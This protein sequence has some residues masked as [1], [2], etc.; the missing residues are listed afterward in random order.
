VLQFARVVFSL[1]AL[2]SLAQ[3]QQAELLADILDAP[4]YGGNSSIHAYGTTGS[5]HEFAQVGGWR[6]FQV[7][8]PEHGAELWRSLGT[9]A[10]TELVV[11]IDP[12]PVGSYPGAFCAWGQ[13]LFFFASPRPGGRALYVSTGKGAVSLLDIGDGQHS[14]FFEDLIEWSGGIAFV[15]DRDGRRELWV[16]DGTQKG[17]RV[18]L[19]NEMH[20]IHPFCSLSWCSARS[21]FWFLEG[22]PSALDGRIWTF[23]PKS[24]KLALLPGAKAPLHLPYGYEKH[25]SILFSG[26]HAFWLTKQGLTQSQASL[27]VGHLVSYD[28]QAATEHVLTQAPVAPD[29]S[30]AK[31]MGRQ[32]YFFS[33]FEKE[34]ELWR[35][36][37]TKAGT[38]LVKKLGAGLTV[39]SALHGERA[40]ER[41]VSWQGK[42][43]F[44]VGRPASGNTPANH[45]M[46]WSTDGTAAGTQPMPHALPSPNS[47]ITLLSTGTEL[48]ASIHAFTPV[49]PIT[50]TPQ[51]LRWTAQG[52][53][54]IRRG[55]PGDLTVH[56]RD[57]A[58]L[59]NGD[60]L[61]DWGDYS[62]ESPQKLGSGVELCAYDP[63]RDAVR[64]IRKWKHPMRTESASQIPLCSGESWLFGT[65][66]SATGPNRIWSYDSRTGKTT[67]A[68]LSAESLWPSADLA[69]S[70]GSRLFFFAPHTSTGWELR[71]WEASEATDKV[72]LDIRPG[73][74]SSVSMAPRLVRSL[75][76]LVFVANDGV[77]GN[78]LWAT[79]GTAKGTRMLFDHAKGQL[80]GVDEDTLV[81]LGSKLLFC[82]E[83]E[84]PGL[85]SYDRIHH[86]STLLM[87]LP[88]AVEVHGRVAMRVGAQA[89]IGVQ[90]YAWPRSVRS[91]ILLSDGT[92]GAVRV[93][94][95]RTDASYPSGLVR[96]GLCLRGSPRAGVGGFECDPAPTHPRG[97]PRRAHSCLRHVDLGEGDQRLRREP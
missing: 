4:A 90:V 20:D 84:R 69:S 89:L 64:V 18:L 80:D 37:G 40:P 22:V 50:G 87:S 42:Q 24:A 83:N 61:F 86:K 58:V 12:G 32:L 45:L 92:Q 52:W 23:D 10:S 65:C 60:L 54:A 75:G 43:L 30:Y 26:T 94:L 57:M 19:S 73:A 66:Y 74:A 35:S 29:F 11:D 72:V 27:D 97:W 59:A 34:L 56:G 93:L 7:N 67:V 1:L 96:C 70:L 85:W 5:G 71:S 63:V 81:A 36:D 3:S 44:G 51:V 38:A 15:T 21:E 47:E 31:L 91:M 53:H 25:R 39:A 55:K 95:D 62:T 78:E 49:A 88:K 2:T 17:T 46:L 28:L 33:A 8:E 41:W 48:Y 82:G 16:S 76:E 77:H 14:Y 13:L 9:A 6:Y 79:D 68:V